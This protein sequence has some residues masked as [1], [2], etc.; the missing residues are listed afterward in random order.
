MKKLFACMLICFGMFSFVQAQLKGTTYKVKKET[1][2]AE[3]DKT[4]KENPG[5][6]KIK[7]KWGGNDQINN[8]SAVSGLKA[9]K[10][11]E[12]IKLKSLDLSPLKGLGNIENIVLANVPLTNIETLGFLPKIGKL[13][14]VDCK[15]T[16]LDFLSKLP[17]LHS[18]FLTGKTLN[19]MTDFSPLVKMQK[20]TSLT[21][22][23][24][25]NVN[26]KNME[27]LKGLKNITFA[28]FQNNE[29]LTNINFLQNC[30]SLEVLNLTDSKNVTDISV[31]SNYTKL[32][33]VFIQGTQ[34]KSIAGIQ[35]SASTLKTVFMINC[36]VSDI[37]P[38][39]KCSQL[40][41]VQTGSNSSVPQSQIDE[42]LKLYPKIKTAHGQ[43]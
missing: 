29:G 42:L 8:I 30:T 26:D 1:T 34:V 43:H 3:F 32:K 18:L 11:I 19:T 31:I 16:S 28:M 25:P 7:F 33:A 23:N 2:Q 27:V 17:N 15:V 20:L 38:L 37:S 22:N 36:P 39:F 24:S 10:T 40:E 12:V 14:I 41:M 21:L 35:S 6:T 13:K 5:I 9:L 4:C